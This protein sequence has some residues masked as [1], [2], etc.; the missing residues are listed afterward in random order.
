MKTL[1]NLLLFFTL[2]I[3]IIYSQEKDL[4]FDSLRSESNSEIKLLPDRIFFTQKV[5]WGE[6]GLFRLTRIY[7]LSPEGR[8]KEIKIRRFMLKSHQVIGYAT[9]AGMIA[10][11]IIGGKLYNGE[12]DLYKTHKNLGNAVTASYFTGAA[13]SLFAPPPLVNKKVKGLNSIKAHKILASLHFPAMVTTKVLSDKDADAH[14][15]A[16]YTAV[17]SYATAMIVFKF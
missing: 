16:A 9:F 5:L 11:G 12:Y 15:I 2:S 8:Q 1:S 3:Q 13:L 6:K 10:Q 17:V 4:L 7:N 14:K